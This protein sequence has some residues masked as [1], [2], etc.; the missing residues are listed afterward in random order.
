MR[1]SGSILREYAGFSKSQIIAFRKPAHSH[2]GHQKHSA[3]TLGETRASNCTAASAARRERG[4]VSQRERFR[5]STRRTDIRVTIQKQKRS[6][7][8]MDPIKRFSGGHAFL[9]NEFPC[10]VHY[11]WSRFRSVHHAWLTLSLDR[12]IFKLDTMLCLLEDKFIV[13]QQL[14]FALCRTYGRQLIYLND[15]GD[16]FWGACKQ[17]G[18]NHL[19]RLLM[20]IRERLWLVKSNRDLCG[21]PGGLE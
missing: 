17:G 10:D 21:R 6:I 8:C 13:H 19:G 1:A 4:L 11:S 7:A 18:E 12:N 16:T 20:N 14:G 9:H 3:E 15:I 2:Q 5:S